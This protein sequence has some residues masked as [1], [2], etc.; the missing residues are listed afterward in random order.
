VYPVKKIL[1][2]FLSVFTAAALAVGL[3]GVA[4]AET[5]QGLRDFFVDTAG[6][7]SATVMVYM[8][9]SD[10]ESQRG[11]ATEDLQEMK[12]AEFG[13]NLHVVVQTMGTKQWSDPA[14][15][16]DTTQR[17]TVEHGELVLQEDNL[18]QL[19]STDPATLQGFIEY[20]TQAYPADR[21]ILI[22]WNHGAGPVYGYGYDEYQGYS[23]SLTIDEIQAALTGSGVLFDFIGMDACLMGS[24]ETC[25][26]LRS[27]ADYLAASEDFEPCSGWDYTGWLTALGENP[28]ISTPELGQL[29]T[30]GFVQESEESGEDGILSM[31]DLRYA[32]QL[33]EA[34]TDFG[35]AHDNALTSANY[36]WKTV[37]TS[38]AAEKEAVEKSGFN[39]DDYY[40][41]DIMAV[42]STI[43]QEGSQ[44][45]SGLLATAIAAYGSTEQRNQMTGLS[46]TLPYGNSRFYQSMVPVFLNSGFETTYL[47]WLGTF[48]DCLDSGTYYTDWE[49]W[50][51]S[52]NNWEDYQEDTDNELCWYREETSGVYY[53]VFSD[54]EI[55][56]FDPISCAFYTYS[57]SE[58]SWWRWS[59]R[60][61]EWEEW[62]DMGFPTGLKNPE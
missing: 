27:C 18:G 31:I 34:W 3:T 12:D 10:L 56:Y 23:A 49:D 58:G 37:P 38:R 25:Y 5:A 36:S 44:E 15:Q 51:R 57:P 50:N 61:Q 13:D 30:E 35:Y 42:A 21:N 16:G 43:D 54:G 60:E 29:I 32:D 59:L 26:A 22:L 4:Q 28:S 1:S 14:V 47:E 7:E 40:I 24:L 8:I 39:M 53:Y 19:D 2:K 41:T 62:A 52:W 45:L 11:I 46:V 48:A 55:T 20:C 33:L 6:A 9:G 17:F